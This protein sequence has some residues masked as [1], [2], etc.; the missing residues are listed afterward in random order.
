V[1]AVEA[2][3]RVIVKLSPWK[4][5]GP[6]GIPNIAI[7][8]ASTTFAP[9]LLAILTAGLRLHHFPAS[10]C[11]FITATLRK[12]GKSDYTAPSAFRPIAEE[13][14][15]GKVVESV[16]TDWLSG[17]AEAKGLLSSRQFGGRP[18]R[19]AVDSVLLLT[20]HIKDVWHVG[21]V[22][23]VLL[24]DISQAFPS[25]SHEHLLHMLGSKRVP[26]DV[27]G[28]IGS[29]L[30]D[31]STTLTFNDHGALD[32]RRRFHGLPTHSHRPRRAASSARAVPACCLPPPPPPS[33]ARSPYPPH[34][35]PLDPSACRCP[36]E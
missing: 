31:R 9:I 19:S 22:A 20:Q 17:F 6:S 21:K 12:P 26:D 27:V 33:P 5:P 11:I 4:A 16:L 30:R 15:L 34:P 24:M 2:F 29:F 28:L 36:Q 14:C 35:L 7:K 18:G 3:H 23:S 25:V 32:E 13:E 10:W 8:A 1:F